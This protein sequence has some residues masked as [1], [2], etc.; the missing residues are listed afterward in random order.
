MNGGTVSGNS[1]GGVEAAV[2]TMNGGDISENSG[3]G[4]NAASGCT[5]T[6]SGG[7][8]S[9]NSSSY[10]GG[11]VYLPFGGTFTMSGGTISGNSASTYG[12]GVYLPSGCTFTMSGGTSNGNSAAYGGGIFV[13]GTSIFLSDRARIDPSN[14]VCLSVLGGDGI[15]FT[16]DAAAL[17][18]DIAVIDNMVAGRFSLPVL[19]DWVGE[20]IQIEGGGPVPESV[21]SR[22]KLKTFYAI[23]GAEIVVTDISGYSIKSDGK[24]SWLMPAEILSFKVNGVEASIARTIT[25]V[26]LYGTDLGNLAPEIV[27]S[28]DATINPESGAARNFIGPIGYRVTAPDGTIKEYTVDIK[29]SG[30]TPRDG[31]VILDGYTPEENDLPLLVDGYA[32]TAGGAGYTNYR[33]YVDGIPRGSAESISLADY[34]PGKHTVS[35]TADKKGVPFQ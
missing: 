10:Y 28:P 24:G 31:I 2:F 30:Y 9:G 21:R 12:G 32:V 33:W 23:L 17:D 18:H 22:F 20:I 34:P 11:G 29:C 35:L 6:M 7:T 1:G 27:V 26:L 8:I 5:F 19:A 14:T 3:G 13:S 25:L 16:G 15:V 4:V